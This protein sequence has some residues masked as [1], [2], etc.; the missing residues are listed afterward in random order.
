M[1]SLFRPTLSRVLS[2]LLCRPRR[3]AFSRDRRDT[4]DLSDAFSRRM[5]LMLCSAQL[6]EDVCQFCLAALGCRECV[7]CG[8]VGGWV[9]GE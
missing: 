2:C 5:L 4:Y 9:V 7:V 8:C 6:E 1:S 3:T